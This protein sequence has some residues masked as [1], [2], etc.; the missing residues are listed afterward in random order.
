[1][2][3]GI[4]ERCGEYRYIN[5]HHIYPQ[6]FFSRKN[7]KTTI[8][9]CLLCHAEIHELLPKEKQSK[10]FYKDFTEK[11]ISG[12]LGVLLLMGILTLFLI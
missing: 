9:L 5:K 7:N 4:C 10:E 12:L 3:K 2:Q 11:F 6:E 8:T 1:M